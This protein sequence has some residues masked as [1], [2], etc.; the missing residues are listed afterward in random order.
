MNPRVQ[1][2]RQ[3]L[4]ALQYSAKIEKILDENKSMQLPTSAADEFA[5]CVNRFLTLQSAI[6]NFYGDSTWLYHVTVKSHVLAHIGLIAKTT[7]NPR[8]V[9]NFSGEDFMGRIKVLAQTSSNG[10]KS[11]DVP[12]KVC[13]KYICG[14]SELVS[15][16]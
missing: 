14:M 7:F 2:Q 9:W 5:E 4:Q 6:R 8:L 15:S 10:T 1:S 13:K 12:N 11:V 3:V 16:Y